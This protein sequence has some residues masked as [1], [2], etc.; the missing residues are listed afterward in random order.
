MAKLIKMVSKDFTKAMIIDD[1][2]YI[3]AIT[4]SGRRVTAWSVENSP[5]GIVRRVFLN[6][7]DRA[8]KARL[9]KALAKAP[10]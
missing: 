6:A 5:N 10:K 2:G 8:V 3:D 1:S 9:R 4:V 7:L